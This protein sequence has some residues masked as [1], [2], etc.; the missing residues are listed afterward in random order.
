VVKLVNISFN[1]FSYNLLH[2][3]L[4]QLAII[5]L[6]LAVIIALTWQKPPKNPISNLNYYQCKITNTLVSQKTLNILL[7][8][9]DN[10]E[11]FAE[12]LCNTPHIG[13]TFSHIN[14]N[15]Q[16]RSDLTAEDL[17]KEKYQVLWARQESLKGMVLHFDDIY[18]MLLPSQ[19]IPLFWL[20]HSEYF[21]LTT[22]F[23]TDKVI[24]L[25]KDQ[26]S[27][28]SYLVPIDS[29]KKQGIDIAKLQINYYDSYKALYDAFNRREIDLVSGNNWF[30][31]IIDIDR[32]TKIPIQHQLDSGGLYMAASVFTPEISCALISAFIAYSPLLDHE[33]AKLSMSK[34]CKE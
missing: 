22:E 33:A 20:S 12:Y 17:L 5:L 21:A 2:Y 26:K 24:G 6:S 4:A 9:A 8:I 16:K 3:R 23:L 32:L 15:W 1:N 29:L 25:I 14:L 13:Q 27:Y 30:G 11:D 7:P 28:S 31:S 19:K 10:A 34:H 18:K